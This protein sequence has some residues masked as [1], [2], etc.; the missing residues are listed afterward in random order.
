MIKFMHTQRQITK[1]T[2]NQVAFEEGVKFAFMNNGRV[3]HPMHIRQKSCMSPDR[4]CFIAGFLK[5]R[6]V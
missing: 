2:R 6:S 5:N 4:D 3:L 1:P